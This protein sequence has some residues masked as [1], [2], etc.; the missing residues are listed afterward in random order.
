MYAFN[1]FKVKEEFLGYP[2][3]ADQ[4]ATKQPNDYDQT[5]ANAEKDLNEK[6]GITQKQGDKKE[7]KPQQN[8]FTHI[9]ILGKNVIN[10]MMKNQSEI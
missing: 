8:Y 2:V 5:P 9:E 10:S 6:N 7:D 4:T 1:T 3:I